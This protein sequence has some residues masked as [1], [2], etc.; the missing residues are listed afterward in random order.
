MQ[1]HSVSVPF[2]H[3][4]EMPGRSFE[5]DDASLDPRIKNHISLFYAAAD[6]TDHEHWAS[7]LSE[8]ASFSKGTVVLKGRENILAQRKRTW[9]DNQKK[10]HIV[11]KVFPLGVG[12]L[13]VMLYG[14]ST[15]WY[16]DGTTAEAAWAARIHYKEVNGD[17]KADLYN[18]Y[19]PLPP[20]N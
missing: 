13:E 19:M 10:E 17:V 8:D 11:F 4:P 3:S 5:C 20:P 1:L 14:K 9:K 2:Q 7:F 18:I 6:T 12:A 16:G 15:W